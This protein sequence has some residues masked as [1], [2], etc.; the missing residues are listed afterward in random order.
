MALS[1]LAKP[2]IDLAVAIGEAWPKPPERRSYLES[3]A[4]PHLRDFVVCFWRREAGGGTVSRRVLPDGCVDIIWMADRPAF[5][6]GPMTVAVQPVVDG[7]KA[8][9]GIRFRPG[10]APAL[11]GV[12][13]S[14][15]LDRNVPLRDLLP[16]RQHDQWER[17]EPGAPVASSLATMT[18]AV[19]ARV[20][21]VSEPDPFIMAAAGWAARNPS[22]Q[23][24]ELGQLSGLSERQVRRRFDQAI[25]YS[26]KM[27][28]RIMR[29]QYLL[30]LASEDQ[31]SSLGL[32]RLALMAGYA[33]Q[34]H[35]TR[36]VAALAGVSPRQLLVDAVH[37]SAVSDL[38]KTR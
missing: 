24:T 19:T 2:P 27:L 35:M 16:Q 7:T 3:A 21:S 6:T 26:P 37:A 31:T 38:F 22:G 17:I 8:I 34:P 11:L 9:A 5:V 15:L 4:P 13:A 25:G 28:Q 10:V 36:E 20:Q 29:L 18:E 33:D 30:W 1:I 12:N 23:L 32:A 14:D